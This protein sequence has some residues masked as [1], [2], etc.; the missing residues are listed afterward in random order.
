MPKIRKI[1]FAFIAK[2]N[3]L[4][5]MMKRILLLF[6]AIAM[7]TTSL[8]QGWSVGVRVGSTLQA[9]GQYQYNA[10]NHIEARIG[11]SWASIGGSCSDISLLHN[12]RVKTMDW[13]PNAGEWFFDAGVGA[14]INGHRNMTR[15][16]VMGMARLGL[17]FKRVPLSLSLDYSP[18][19]GP[20]IYRHEYNLADGTPQ[21]EHFSEFNFFGLYNGGFTLTYHF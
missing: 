15:F 20:T 8:A 5:S 14:S 9:V 21:T 2:M 17:K 6:A 10:S 4:C 7:A 18:T 1:H 12:W 16:G 13:T 3:Y 11:V 19:F